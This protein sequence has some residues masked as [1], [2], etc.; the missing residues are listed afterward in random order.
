MSA[1]SLLS[2][3]S[4][5]L[6]GLTRTVLLWLLG[7]VVFAV[8]PIAILAAITLLL[9]QP[10]DN[11]LLLKEWSFA[12]IVLFAVSI[13]RLIRLKVNVQRTPRSYKLDTGVQ[14]FVLLLVASTVTLTLVALAEQRVLPHS[15]TETLAYAQLCLFATAVV[16]LLVAT[17][18][19]ERTGVSP[20]W[21]PPTRLASVDSGARLQSAIC[22]LESIEAGLG[23]GAVPNAR[24]EPPELTVPAA[25]RTSTEQALDHCDAVLR[26]IRQHLA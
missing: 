14:L 1:A 23:L 20:P 10:F 12:S 26:R 18:A 7:D 16:S 19:E 2:S 3:F 11:F 8:V 13:R 9:G 6:R 21:I 17:L 5:L 22:L 4:R 24:G 15:T 25:G